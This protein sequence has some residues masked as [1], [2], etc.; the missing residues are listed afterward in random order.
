[1]EIGEKIIL[2]LIGGIENWVAPI[3]FLQKYLCVFVKNN[4]NKSFFLQ[5]IIIYNRINQKKYSNVLNLLLKYF[6][7]NYLSIIRPMTSTT[8]ARHGAKS[9]LIG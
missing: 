9:I 8:Y 3:L 6:T 7:N 1:M 5:K 4:I 2:V